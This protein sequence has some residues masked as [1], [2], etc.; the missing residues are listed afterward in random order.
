MTRFLLFDTL[1]DT[2]HKQLLATGKP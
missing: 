1:K 2:Q